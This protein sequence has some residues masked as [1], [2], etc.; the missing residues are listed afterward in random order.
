M[1][2]F[3]RDEGGDALTEWKLLEAAYPYLAARLLGISG[4]EIGGQ[5]NPRQYVNDRLNSR[6][7]FLVTESDGGADGYLFYRYCRDAPSRW[8]VVGSGLDVP[9]DDR[10]VE[11][12]CRFYRS[13]AV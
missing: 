7:L 6:V 10:I 8:L 9:T 11:I 13:S 5:L 3:Y 4:A 1:S 12:L 2:K